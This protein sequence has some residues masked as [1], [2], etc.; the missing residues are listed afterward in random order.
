MVASAVASKSSMLFMTSHIKA[1]TKIDY[2]YYR[3][4]YAHGIKTADLT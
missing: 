4:E 3:R 2:C 1:N